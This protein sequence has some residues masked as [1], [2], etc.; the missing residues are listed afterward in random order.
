MH[1]IAP[2]RCAQSGGASVDELDC[3][4]HEGDPRR[5]ISTPEMCDLSG[6]TFRQL[7]YWAR[8]GLLV[9]T[10]EARGSGTRRGYSTNQVGRATALTAVSDLTHGGPHGR[11]RLLAEVAETEPPWQ[12]RHGRITITVDLGTP[13]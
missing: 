5:L 7:D 11:S 8:A 13:A 6:A 4:S 9:P 12:L 2:A 10:A 3:E 1:V